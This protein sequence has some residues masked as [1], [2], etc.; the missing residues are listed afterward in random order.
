[1]ETISNI[2][3]DMRKLAGMLRKKERVEGYEIV[4]SWSGYVHFAD[5][6]ERSFAVYAKINEQQDMDYA[7]IVL[8]V[9]NLADSIFDFSSML[10]LGRCERCPSAGD[11]DSQRC[12]LLIDELNNIVYKEKGTNQ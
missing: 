10:C 12:R 9:H 2:V 11:C 3:R 6:I 7:R 1:M 4:N 5:R 8:K